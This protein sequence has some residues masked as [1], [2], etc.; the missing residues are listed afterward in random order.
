MVKV[1]NLSAH[2]ILTTKNHKQKIVTFERKTN[3]DKS[4]VARNTH[5]ELPHNVID[6]IPDKPHINK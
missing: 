6:P 5:K 4:V 3:L 2:L 1:N